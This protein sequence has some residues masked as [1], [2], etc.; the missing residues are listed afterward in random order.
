MIF[1]RFFKTARPRQFNYQTR[2]YDAERE[3]LEIRVKA[4]R[5]ASNNPE[6]A[7]R[8]VRLS[9]EFTSMRSRMHSP[10]KREISRSRLR[11]ILILLVIAYF[12]Y[13]VLMKW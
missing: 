7:E 1:S 6:V 5:Q 10:R 2:Y 4:A 12:C 9:Y 11:F 3:D 8:Q 13:R